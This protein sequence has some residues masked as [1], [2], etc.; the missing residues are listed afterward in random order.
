[1]IAWAAT[2]TDRS[3]CGLWNSAYDFENEELGLLKIELTGRSE[4]LFS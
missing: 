1:M 2:T 4:V 3:D